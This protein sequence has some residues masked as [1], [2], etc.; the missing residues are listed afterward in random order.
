MTRKMVTR[1]LTANSERQEAAWLS[2]LTDTEFREE[3]QK[4]YGFD[5]MAKRPSRL[6]HYDVTEK[7][8]IADFKKGSKVKNIDIAR[9]LGIAKRHSEIFGRDT[10]CIKS[11]LIEIIATKI[12]PPS[13]WA[14]EW[15]RINLEKRR[16]TFRHEQ[17]Q[18][19]AEARWAK[20]PDLSKSAVA[21]LLSPRDPS[22]ANW[23]RQVI[24]KK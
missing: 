17:L 19:D 9:A 2:K 12:V 22:T 13:V 1:P 24:K 14:R 8:L 10:V 7:K 3:I 15:S 18:R 20:N 16:A 11:E 21:R 4:K 23:I 6:E 5:P